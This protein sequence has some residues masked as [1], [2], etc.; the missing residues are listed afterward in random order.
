LRSATSRDARGFLSVFAAETLG[1][2]FL[3]GDF[4]PS[5]DW[6]HVDRDRIVQKRQAGEVGHDSRPRALGPAT[7]RKH[8]VVVPIEEEPAPAWP[9]PSPCQQFSCMV[10]VGS[11]NS[12]A[13]SDRAPG[14]TG[15]QEAS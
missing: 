3:P 9:T 6:S 11:N 14:M 8:G 13:I 12:A 2:L 5:G 1:R 4:L 10:S 15:V 7:E